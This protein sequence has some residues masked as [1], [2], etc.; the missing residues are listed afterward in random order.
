VAALD[1]QAASWRRSAAYYLFAN[2]YFGLDWALS[3]QY[4]AEICTAGVWDACFKYARSAWEYADQLFKD[5]DPCAAVPQYEASLLTLEDAGKAPTATEA[6]DVCL[7]ATAQSPTPTATLDLTTTAT[8]TG[9]LTGPT[10]TPTVTPT[11]APPAT[12]TPTATLGDTPTPTATAT[13]TTTDTPTAT[14]TPG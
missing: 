9:T 4:F 10:F 7:T 11:G 2:S 13:P 3:T 1:S 8:P 5:E 12:P 6:F 14:D